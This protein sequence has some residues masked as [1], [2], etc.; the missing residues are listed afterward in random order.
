MERIP[1]TVIVN[2]RMGSSDQ[3]WITSKVDLTNSPFEDNL[4]LYDFGK[5][6]KADTAGKFAYDR[7]EDLIEVDL[8]PDDDLRFLEAQDGQNEDP[9]AHQDGEEQRASEAGTIT[10]IAPKEGYRNDTAEARRVRLRPSNHRALA[11]PEVENDLTPLHPDPIWTDKLSGEKL[12]DQRHRLA[13]DIRKALA[14]AADR[15]GAKAHVLFII[16]QE[17]CGYTENE[18]HVV[19]VDPE[20]F[21]A[22]FE[23]AKTTGRIHVKY[24]MQNYGESLVK[25]VK[26]C[27]FWPNVHQF[28]P[29]NSTI[30]TIVPMKPDKAEMTIRK[31]PERYLWYQNTI[32]L[33]DMCVHGP[34]FFENGYIIP[35]AAWKSLRAFARIHGS[36]YVKNLDRVVP[37]GQVDP[38]YKSKSGKAADAFLARRFRMP[39]DYHW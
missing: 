33:L 18:W 10:E 15:K 8:D 12:S 36:L 14:N 6:I 16:Q 26:D 29:N 28:Q 39:D 23:R 3:R 32:D 20:A 22:N 5:Y 37:L 27:K 9:S 21:A 2:H 17:R 1:T 7:I 25:K 35:E 4:G 31:F 11:Q 38:E 13:E 24:W 30:G 19:S 34:F